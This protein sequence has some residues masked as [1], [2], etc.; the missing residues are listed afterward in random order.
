VQR[1]RGGGGQSYPQGRQF[2]AA[3][4]ELAQ[5]IHLKMF[6]FVKS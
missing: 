5:E 2:V 1:Q 3:W 4:Y 6:I